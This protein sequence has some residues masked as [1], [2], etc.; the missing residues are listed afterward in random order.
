MIINIFVYAILMIINVYGSFH[1]N[2]Y[3]KMIYILILLIHIFMGYSFVNIILMILFYYLIQITIFMLIFLINYLLI[4][5]LL[6][7]LQ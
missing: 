5:M 4:F 1:G 2:L 3:D 7:I 6:I